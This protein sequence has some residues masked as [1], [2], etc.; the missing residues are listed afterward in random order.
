[1]TALSFN[2]DNTFSDQKVIDWFVWEPVDTAQ[3]LNEDGA[4]HPFTPAHME[5]VALSGEGSCTLS[6]PVSRYSETTREISLQLPCTIKQ[7]LDA[8]HQFYATQ[9]PVN[10]ELKDIEKNQYKDNVLKNGATA[11]WLDLIGSRFVG[12]DDG[13]VDPN[14]RRSPFMCNGLVRFE[15]LDKV[16]ETVYTL[17]NGS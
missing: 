16:S 3:L 8:I 13:I 4:A 14:V 10:D 7:L 17:V 5:S 6:L 2:L 9:I 11:T 1:M 12:P 15:G